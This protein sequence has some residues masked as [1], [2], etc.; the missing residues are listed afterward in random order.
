M[1]PS[2]PVYRLLPPEGVYPCV[3]E[4]RGGGSRWPPDDR[5]PDPVGERRRHA[6]CQSGARCRRPQGEHG[7]HTPQ[8]AV[9]QHPPTGRSPQTPTPNRAV[10][11]PT[12]PPAPHTPQDSHITQRAVPHHPRGQSHTLGALQCPRRLLKIIEANYHKLSLV[13][14]LLNISNLPQFNSNSLFGTQV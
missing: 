7:R 8:R 9:P 12:G 4:G 10:P 14:T 13:I 6:Q 5:G 11:P 1:Y 3:G 2:T